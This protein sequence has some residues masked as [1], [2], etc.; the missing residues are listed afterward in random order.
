MRTKN[1]HSYTY[2]LSTHHVDE[3]FARLESAGQ[4]PSGERVLYCDTDGTCI[5]DEKGDSYLDALAD[6][7]NAEAGGGKRLKQLV[8]RE[9]QMIAIWEERRK[10]V[11]V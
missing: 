5:F 3:V 9:Q 10:E 2:S 1:K 7:L 11:E 6:I 8:F 4:T